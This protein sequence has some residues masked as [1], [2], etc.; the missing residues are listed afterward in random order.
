[1]TARPRIVP[2]VLAG[3]LVAACDSKEAE[4]PSLPAQAAAP[5]IPVPSN[6]GPGPQPGAKVGARDLSIERYVGTALPKQEAELGPRMSGTLASVDVEEGQMVK[7]GQV[8]F[9][10]DARS[11]RL[12]VSQAE[13]G[14]QGAQIARDNAK[15]ELERQQQLAAKGTVAAAVLERAESAFNSAENNVSQAGVALSMARRGTADSAVVSP[16]DGLVAHKFKDVGETVTM[17]PPTIVV[18]IQDQSVLEVRARIPE[19]ALRLVHV[20]DQVSAHFTALAVSREAKV[21]R[22]QPTVDAATRTIEIVTDVD[23]KDGALRPGMYVEI[24]LRPPLASVLPGAEGEKPEAAPDAKAEVAKASPSK[25][26]PSDP[27]PPSAGT[28]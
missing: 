5:T 23:N 21:V 12:G 11:T 16:I 1:M 25:K 4:K 8:L 26:A 24:E 15:R 9:R 7:K 6:K 10:L 13:T 20:G 19:A 3:L 22:V 2:L 17:M 27:P 14:L 28:H 18:V